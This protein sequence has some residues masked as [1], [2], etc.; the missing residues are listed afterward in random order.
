[1]NGVDPTVT[2]LVLSSFDEVSEGTTAAVYF[3]NE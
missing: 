3:R 2:Q 1:L